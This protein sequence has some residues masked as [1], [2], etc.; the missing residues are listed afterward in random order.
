MR[1]ILAFIVGGITVA[2]YFVGLTYRM[3][4]GAVSPLIAPGVFGTFAFIIW[5]IA[6]ACE[7]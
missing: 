7:E 3:S 6:H 1:E 5:V 2:S 4:D